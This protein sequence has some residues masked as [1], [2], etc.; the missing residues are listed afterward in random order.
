ME[1]IWKDI[2]RYKG[3]YQAS[4]LG[5]IRN[6]KGYVLNLRKQWGGFV[7]A[8]LNDRG[9]RIHRLVAE[10]FIP[11]PNNLPYVLH[12]DNDK[13]NNR[14]ENLCW[15]NPERNESLMGKQFGD[16]AVI[17]G[18][19]RHYAKDETWNNYYLVDAYFVVWKKNREKIC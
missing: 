3:K 4:N 15:S 2:P 14:V 18:P 11:N 16:F 9:V 7:T 17:S 8:C 19:D 12:K 6:K 10:T 5:R 13:T 1:E